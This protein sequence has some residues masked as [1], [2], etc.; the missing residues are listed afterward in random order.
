MT[1]QQ[2]TFLVARLNTVTVDL[3]PQL[4]NSEPNYIRDGATTG[5][6]P[7]HKL[8]PFFFYHFTFI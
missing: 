4:C 5:F 1:V 3:I 2:V 7:A 6:G 8:H